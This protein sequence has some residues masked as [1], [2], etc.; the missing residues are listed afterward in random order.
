VAKVVHIKLT[1]EG[2]ID[3]ADFDEQLQIYHG[4]IAL[5]ALSG[6][7]NVTG[8]ISPARRLAEK[9]HAAGAQILVD[10]AQMAPI[11]KFKCLPLDDPA[12]FD[13]VALSAHK[14]YAPFG[15]GAL[16]GRRDTFENGIPDMRGGG[17][18]KS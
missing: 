4:R 2:R 1:S 17:K 7:S 3:E 5:V 13:Y 12:H 8:F 6:A 18:W 16:I 9:A 15:C 10:C 11:A 14:M